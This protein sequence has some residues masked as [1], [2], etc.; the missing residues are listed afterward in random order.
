M[1]GGN[2]VAHT[3][4]IE[5]H[6]AFWLG[7]LKEGIHLGDLGAYGRIILKLISQK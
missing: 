3:R 4:R 6:K 2:F 1:R 7:N 5:I